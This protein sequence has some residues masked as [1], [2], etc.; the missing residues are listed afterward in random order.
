[1][2]TKFKSVLLEQNLVASYQSLDLGS[3]ARP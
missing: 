2:Y 3:K 1:M